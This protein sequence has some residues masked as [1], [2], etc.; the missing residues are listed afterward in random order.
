MDSDAILLSICQTSQ[1]V[2]LS[3]S[4]ANLNTAVVTLTDVADPVA[5]GVSWGGGWGPGHQDT[6]DTFLDCLQV[7]WEGSNW[8]RI[9]VGS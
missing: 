1:K 7:C 3:R 4:I 9:G 8:R 2:A 6:G 5:S